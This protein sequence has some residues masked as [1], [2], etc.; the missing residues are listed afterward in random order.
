MSE[1]SPLK[2]VKKFKAVKDS[3]FLLSLV[4]KIGD[5]DEKFKSACRRKGPI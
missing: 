2:H 3:Y 1:M 4:M 5:F